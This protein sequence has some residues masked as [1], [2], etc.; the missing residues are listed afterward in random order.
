MRSFNVVDDEST[1]NGSGGINV[2][3]AE[4]VVVLKVET[5]I[6]CKSCNSKIVQ[7]GALGECS[8]CGAKI[9][10]SKCKNKHVGQVN[11]EDN[12]G[13]EHK[14]TMLMKYSSK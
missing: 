1:F 6:G 14:L 12:T 11:L 9:K 10:I 3:E 7:E 13:N 4:I 2:T 5:Y 8:K